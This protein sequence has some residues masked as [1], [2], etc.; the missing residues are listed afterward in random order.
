MVNSLHLG[1]RQLSIAE[2]F[3]GARRFSRREDSERD[4][5]YLEGRVALDVCDAGSCGFW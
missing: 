3:G 4:Q 1:C 5:R 2:Q